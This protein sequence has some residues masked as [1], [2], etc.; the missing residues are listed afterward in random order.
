MKQLYPNNQSHYYTKRLVTTTLPTTFTQLLHVKHIPL[1]VNSLSINKNKTILGKKKC[2]A[3]G[4]GS[5]ADF[6]AIYTVSKKCV[7]KTHIITV[8]KYNMN[9]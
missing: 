8:Y 6:I 3:S 1:I 4:I 9:S 5:F 7:V 2:F